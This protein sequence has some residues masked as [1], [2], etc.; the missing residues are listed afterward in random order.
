M[1]LVKVT[2]PGEAPDCARGLTA[3]RRLAMAINNKAP[4][5]LASMATPSL[6]PIWGGPLQG[7]RL[8]H[9]LRDRDAVHV[10]EPHVAAVEAVRQ[11]LVID[12]EQLKDRRVQIV[13]RNRLLL[14]LVAEVVARA[15]RLSALDARACH[16]DRH[17]ARIVIASDAALLVRHPA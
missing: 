14:R 6:D 10:R 17:R 9:D 4:R 16:P 7:R 15:D 8:R 1:S 11:L 5:S 12:P 2:S 13:I 3:I